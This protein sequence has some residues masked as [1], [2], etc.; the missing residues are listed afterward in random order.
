MDYLKQTQLLGSIQN[1]LYWDQNT[2]MPKKGASWRAE[3]L[4]ILQRNYTLEILPKSLLILIDSA[5]QEL[6]EFETEDE[7]NFYEKKEIFNFYTRN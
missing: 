3:Q 6:N 2:M 4:T 7:K 5:N 1:T